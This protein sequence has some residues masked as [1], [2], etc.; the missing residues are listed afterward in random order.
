MTMTG[1]ADSVPAT[2][3]PVWPSTVDWG[4]LGNLR[5]GDE[6]GIGDGVGDGAQAGAEDD[7]EARGEAAEAGAQEGGSGVDLVVVGKCHWKYFKAGNK[8]EGAKG[9]R[10]RGERGAGG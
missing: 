4:K 7:G 6:D 8:D 5:V 1:F 10:K 9:T 2:M 3:R